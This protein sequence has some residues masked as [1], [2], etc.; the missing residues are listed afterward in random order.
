MPRQWPTGDGTHS[1]GETSRLRVKIPAVPGDLAATLE[2]TP[3]VRPPQ[4]A[5]RVLISVNGA[6]VHETSLSG[7]APQKVSF[8]IPQA[9]IAGAQALDM[10]FDYPDS[11]SQTPVASNIYD[12]A[13]KL[14]SFRLDSAAEGVDFGA[15][16]RR[17]APQTPS[18]RALGD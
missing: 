12:R 6:R 10:V 3:M 9:V 18:G 11:I 15:T 16:D 17:S 2:M 14:V 5:Q 8:V 1:L 7:G 4:T 13:I